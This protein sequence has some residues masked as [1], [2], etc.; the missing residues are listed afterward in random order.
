M[1]VSFFVFSFNRDN[2]TSYLIKRLLKRG[3][4]F[5]VL[6]LQSHLKMFVST[7]VVCHVCK[8]LTI[9][10]RRMVIENFANLFDP[11]RDLFN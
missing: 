5:K 1:L 4:V 10:N 11:S 9:I 3:V 8:L 2:S 7:V 6:P